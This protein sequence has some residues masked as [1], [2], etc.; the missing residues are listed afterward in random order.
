MIS[1][2]FQYFFRREE[3]GDLDPK[4]Y[5]RKPADGGATVKAAAI[6]GRG[7]DQY[8]RAPGASAQRVTV[9]TK[10]VA[11]AKAQAHARYLEKE[12]AGLDGAEVHGFTATKDHVDLKEMTKEWSEDWHFF[13]VIISPEHGDQLDMQRY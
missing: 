6:M 2:K 3:A 7:R 9:K 12:A 4:M 1:R 13:Q 11:A 5:M 8:V 10:V